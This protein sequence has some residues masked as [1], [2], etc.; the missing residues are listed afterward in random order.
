MERG[1]PF[2]LAHR[3]LQT[4]PFRPAQRRAPGPRPR[5]R[6]LGTVPGVGVPMV[7]LSGTPRR[8]SG[9]RV[10]RRTA[11]GRAVTDARRRPTPGAGS[12]TRA[13]GTT[14]YWATFAAAARE[15][16]PRLRPVRVLP[17]RRRH[18]R[19]PR[20]PP[21]ST[22]ARRRS[23]TS[24]EP[25]LR[26]PRRR[27]LRRRPVLEAVV[28]TVRAFG[29]DPDCFEPLPPLDDDGPDRRRPTRPGTTCSTT[30]T[31]RRR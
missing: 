15:A 3:F 7:L 28:H 8:R 31:G 27:R 2:A 19:R 22:C 26:R 1:T 17:L 18:R 29:I 9:R 21:R 25:V 6:R 5:V 11:D 23:P 13:H 16:P 20:R 24:G 14:Y 12:S 30:W 4:G 10:R